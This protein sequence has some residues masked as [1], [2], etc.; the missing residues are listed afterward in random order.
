[1]PFHFRCCSLASALCRRDA[2]RLPVAG[3]LALAVAA[4]LVSGDAVRAFPTGAPLWGITGNGSMPTAHT[5]P[6]KSFEAGLAYENIDP[7]GGGRVEFYPIGTL[8]YGLNR[9]EVGVG[10]LREDA[11]IPITNLD[12]KTTF[13]TLHGKYRVHENSTRGLGVAVGAH[14]LDFGST[15]GHVTS[16]YAVATQRLTRPGSRVQVE[17]SVGLLHSRIDGLSPDNSTR[18][19]FCTKALRSPGSLAPLFNALR[20]ITNS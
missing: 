12:L 20:P 1:M 7:Q 17:G 10:V 9:A 14:Y 16:L 6:R 11:N 8:S 3:A 4:T 15:P 19:P 18:P 2:S 5:V 13:K